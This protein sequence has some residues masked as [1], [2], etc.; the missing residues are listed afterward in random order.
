[1]KIK[2]E[3]QVLISKHACTRPAWLQDDLCAFHH[4]HYM[5]QRMRQ[6]QVNYYKDRKGIA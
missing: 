1:M 5:H 6:K 3:T 2:P 4:R